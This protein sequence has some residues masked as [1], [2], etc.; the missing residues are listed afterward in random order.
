MTKCDTCPSKTGCDWLA[1][2]CLLTARELVRVRPELI[3]SVRPVPKRRLRTAPRPHSKTTAALGFRK[4]DKRL[5]NAYG[6]KEYARG[7]S[8]AR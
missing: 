8:F 2:F 1:D 7:R 5:L 6:H 4:Y 3:Q